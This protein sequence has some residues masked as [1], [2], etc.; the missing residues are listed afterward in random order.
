[1]APKRGQYVFVDRTPHQTNPTI[2]HKRVP[3]PYIAQPKLQPKLTVE[4]D[5]SLSRRFRYAIYCH[6]LHQQRTR[7]GIDQSRHDRPTQED[8]YA[9]NKTD[10]NAN[11]RES[12]V[13]IRTVELPPEPTVQPQATQA[14]RQYTVDKIVAHEDTPE[15]HCYRVGWYGYT[16]KDDTLEP[17][18]HVP[19]HFLDAYWRRRDA[20]SC[21]Q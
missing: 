9:E 13:E 19:Q 20:R 16:A 6:Y 3:A 14:S 18:N 5:R 11:A 21:R 2:R 10:D 1:M 17:A 12:P 4:I 7:H 15:G 8:S